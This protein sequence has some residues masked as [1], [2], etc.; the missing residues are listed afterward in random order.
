MFSTSQC[1]YAEAEP[2]LERSQTILEKALGP[3]HPD[4][5]SVLNT[6][7]LVLNDQVGIEYQ[8]CL[9]VCWNFPE[10]RADITPIKLTTQYRE[11]IYIQV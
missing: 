9:S 6:R 2:L 7:G 4:V 8:C 3:E 10:A 5:A 11:K 1:K